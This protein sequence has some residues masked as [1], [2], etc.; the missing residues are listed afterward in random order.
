MSSETQ[1]AGW[2]LPWGAVVWLACLGAIVGPRPGH[3]VD[4]VRV[5][6]HWELRIAT[7][8][9]GNNAPQATCVMSPVGDIRGLHAV[10]EINQRTQPAFSPGGFQLQLWNGDAPW[11]CVEAGLTEPLGHTDETVTWT[12]VMEIANGVL[13][14]SVSGG[15][16]TT[17]G[18][19][20]GNDLTIEVP[21]EL[22]NLNQYDPLVS[23]H[24]SAVGFAA[25]RVKSLSLKRVRIVSATGEVAE[26]ATVHVVHAL[27]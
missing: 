21:T 16:S 27:P 8:D 7:P 14:F 26:D 20:G 24:H 9:P 18:S 25:N 10:F 22:A 11:A 2:R 19:F 3:A 17:W 5:E 15:Q 12:Q 6:E 13:R 1:N 23:V 4:V